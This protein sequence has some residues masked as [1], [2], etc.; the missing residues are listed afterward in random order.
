[1]TKYEELCK[2]YAKNL[3]DFK[4]YKEL[5]YHFAIN[6]MEQLKQEFNIPPDRLQLRSKEDSKETTDNMLEAMDMQK[7]T[8][9]H[10]RFSITVCSEADEQLKESMSFE[11]CIKKLPSHFLLSIPNEREFIILEKEEGYNFSE[12][13]SYLFTS[14]KNFYEQ[15]LERFL[16]TAPSTSSGKKEQS[17]IGFRFDVIDD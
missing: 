10:I 3:S 7:D 17:P 6:L 13:F 12:F 11:I 2:A 8:F 4:T 14:L 16:S 1:M 15:E 5:C 9:W